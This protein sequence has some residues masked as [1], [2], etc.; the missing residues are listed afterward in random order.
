MIIAMIARTIGYYLDS[1][2]ISDTLTAA[3]RLGQVSEQLSY[4]GPMPFGWHWTIVKRENRFSRFLFLKSCS[5]RGEFTLG[6][7]EMLDILM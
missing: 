6:T 4:V 7:L 2:Y 3:I 5:R 1:C